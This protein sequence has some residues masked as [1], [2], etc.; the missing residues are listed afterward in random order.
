MH[1][2]NLFCN[3]RVI[4]RVLW[5]Q[6]LIRKPVKSTFVFNLHRR[7]VFGKVE[8]FGS[9]QKRKV[10]KVKKAKA[11]KNKKVDDEDSPQ[12]LNEDLIEQMEFA[13]PKSKKGK[14]ALL[15]KVEDMYNEVGDVQIWTRGYELFL[16]HYV[17]KNHKA[18]I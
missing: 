8:S 16:Y 1:E 17:R 14:F 10:E 18:P 2:C 12:K 3:K 6:N 15:D 13:G 7:F 4:I 5:S 9:I 11:N